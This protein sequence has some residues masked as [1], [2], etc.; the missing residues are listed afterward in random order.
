MIR[1]LTGDCREVLRTLPDESVHCVVTSPPY[2]GLRDYGVAGQ[3]GL[4]A[5]PDAFVAVM[6]AVFREVR[7]VL[8]KDGTLFLNL[9]DSYWANGPRQTGRN[10]TD[11]ETPGGRGGSFRG[12]VRRAI[13][14][15]TADKAPEDSQESGCSLRKSL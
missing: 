11:R 13:S 5:T 3:I 1:L 6:V 2:F 9:G 12:G 15:G 8:R 14:Y 4:E 7:R 10:D